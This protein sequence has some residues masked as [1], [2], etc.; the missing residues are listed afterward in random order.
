LKVDG[1]IVPEGTPQ[2][3]EAADLTAASQVITFDVTLPGRL[4]PAE[5][6]EWNG[7]PSV[8]ANY[9]AFRDAVRSRV[10]VLVRE[11]AEAGGR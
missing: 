6:S 3:I 11:L 5:H 8:S 4:H 9:S 10:E 1:F 2:R 7:T